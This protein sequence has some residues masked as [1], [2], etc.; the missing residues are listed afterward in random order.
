[1]PSTRRWR[2]GSLA[3][4]LHL[5]RTGLRDAGRG[6]LHTCADHDVP[7]AQALEADRGRAYRGFTELISRAKA[8]GRLPWDFSD[9]DLIV[10]LTANAGVISAAGAAAPDAWRRLVG[11]MLQAFSAANS[12]PLPPAPK[13]RTCS[14]PWSMRSRA[15]PSRPRTLCLGCNPGRLAHG[16]IAALNGPLQ[17]PT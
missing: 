16:V 7:T 8:A 9:K 1:M 2:T 6:P 11:Y 4:L 15:D 14:A 13:G 10:L 5:H 3:R 12:E 17:S